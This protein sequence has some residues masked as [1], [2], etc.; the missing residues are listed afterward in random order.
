MIALLTGMIPFF[1]GSILVLSLMTRTLP[2]KTG[3]I[4][5]NSAIISD[6]N[7]PYKKGII[8]VNST[9]TND[10]N[11]PYK[12]DNTIDWYYLFLYREDSGH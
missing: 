8:S 9:I 11:A 2:A 7:A 10:Q 5:V 4:P 3:I 1:A 12:N 6:L